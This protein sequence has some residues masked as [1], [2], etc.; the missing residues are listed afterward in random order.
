MKLKLKH[1]LWIPA[2]I[3]AVIIAFA[4]YV[5]IGMNITWNRLH[6]EMAAYAKA[7]AVEIVREVAILEHFKK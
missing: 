1:L 3:V 2:G 4:L 6:N 5:I 7:N